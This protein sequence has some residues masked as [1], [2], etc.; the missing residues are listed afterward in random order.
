MVHLCPVLP[1]VVIIDALIKPHFN[2]FLDDRASE[3]SH[4]VSR[5]GE[6]LW[7]RAQ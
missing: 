6:L 2:V 5:H 1:V 4:V 3:S 7:K